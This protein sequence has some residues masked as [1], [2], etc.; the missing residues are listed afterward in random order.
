MVQ[1]VAVSKNGRYVYFTD[2]S[3]IAVQTDFRDCATFSNARADAVATSCTGRLIRYD[4]QTRKSEVLLRGLSFAN[5]IAL[6]EDE[7]FL[8]VAETSAYRL[9]QY[10]LTGKC[11]HR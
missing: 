3:Q 6:S 1:S 8:V 11:V 10:W 4:T 5:G 2:S 9:R 7:S